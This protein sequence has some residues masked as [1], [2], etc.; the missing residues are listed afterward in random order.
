MPRLP[1]RNLA[2]IPDRRRWLK[3]SAPG[4][5]D[6]ER[7]R[8]E[9]HIAADTAPKSTVSHTEEVRL[10]GSLYDLHLLALHATESCATK[11]SGTA[12]S[13]VWVS[14]VQAEAM[15]PGLAAAAGQPIG[16]FL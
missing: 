7:G 3:P 1:V 4:G 8:G 12:S 13:L 10:V 9:L 6:S 5:C 11:G 14:T 16:I 2:K 15:A